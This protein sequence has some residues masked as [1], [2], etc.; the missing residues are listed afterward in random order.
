MHTLGTQQ[1]FL[2]LRILVDVLPL[3]VQ[4]QAGASDTWLVAPA[5]TV[6]LR[7]S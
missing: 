7:T 5:T 3:G 2:L 4:L 1:D 6:T